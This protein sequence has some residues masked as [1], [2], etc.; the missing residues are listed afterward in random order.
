[1]SSSSQPPTSRFHPPIFMMALLLS[2]LLT[3][4]GVDWQNPPRLATATAQADAAAAG[5]LDPVVVPAPTATPG[6][7]TAVSPAPPANLNWPT[8]TVWVNETSAAHQAALDAMVADF[9]P[10]NQIN[11]EVRLVGPGLLP[12]LMETAVLSD[13][14]PDLVL[15]PL[16]YSAEWAARGILNTA[17]AETAVAAI[18]RDTF[19]PDALALLGSSGQVT[20]VPSDGYQQLFLYRQDWFTE[21]N[22]DPPDTY[23]AMLTAA[24]AIS[25]TANLVRSFIIPTESNLIT[26]HRAFE[27]MAIANGCQ[28]IAADGT[29][30]ILEP[31]CQ[32]A[33]DH[34]FAIVNRYSPPGVQTDTS[35]LNAYLEGRTGMIMGPPT[36]LPILAGLDVAN[37]PRCPD[38]DTAVPNNLAANTGILTTLRGSDPAATGASYGQIRSWGITTAANTESA[39]TFLTYWFN[40]GYDT[41]LA[42]DSVAKV[43]MRW[44]TAVAPTTFIDTWGSQPLGNG[45]LSLADIYGDETVA[46]LRDGIA[47][48]PRWGFSGGQ[49]AVMGPLSRDLT[50][51]VVLQEMLSG[52][53]T[54]ARTLTEANTR[55]LDALTGSD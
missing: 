3:A 13:T 21:R 29:V 17:A 12:D 2:L 35:A 30:V 43:P 36:L 39:L 20:A 42:V 4:C 16:D 25:D 53:F 22:L 48:S 33:L 23:G 32:Q 24:E 14:L 51:S 38:C 6:G 19:N 46:Q 9:S 7:A 49:G 18:G 31:V 55:I 45:T 8:I 11:V 52:Y 15:H 26:T 40:E 47:T 1:M 37:V 44:G 41:W 50:F 10:A 27:H 54:P 34:Y 5:P 28:L